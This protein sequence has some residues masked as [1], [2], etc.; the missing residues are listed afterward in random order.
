MKQQQQ[1]TTRKQERVDKTTPMKQKM[2]MRQKGSMK[3]QQ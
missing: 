2:N 3:K 1:K